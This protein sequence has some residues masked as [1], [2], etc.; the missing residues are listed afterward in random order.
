M[1][2]AEKKW[3]YGELPSLVEKGIVS[4]ETM[5]ALR[6]HYGPL[7]E[8]RSHVNIAFLITSITGAILISAGIIAIVAHNWDELGRMA[9]TVFSLLPLILAQCLYGYAFMKRRSSDAWME[10]TS[11]FLTLMMLSSMALISQTYNLGGNM[12]DLLL[13]W[14][15]LIL[16]VLYLRRVVL[17]F[18]FLMV[19]ICSRAADM[20]YHKDHLENLISY[21]AFILSICPFLYALLSGSDYKV[22]K[23]MAGW[24]LLISI[25]ISIPFLFDSDNVELPVLY[26]AL[27]SLMYL[28]GRYFYHNTSYFWMRPFQTAAIGGG[29]GL[30]LMYTYR[31]ISGWRMTHVQRH[32]SFIIAVSAVV[33]L[34]GLLVVLLQRKNRY[35]N[36]FPAGMVLVVVLLQLLSEMGYTTAVTILANAFLLSYAV[37]YIWQGIS[38]RNVNIVN[39]GMLFISALAIARFFE[40]DMDF[41]IKGLGFII[42]GSGFLTANLLINRR[43]KQ[44]ES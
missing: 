9:R 20:E 2:E 16:P 37:Y 32:T 24:S 21:T 25:C 30:C 22:G 5:Q 43:L 13:V 33:L 42:V 28:A 39:V 26:A 14:G 34:S 19:C 10:S 31:F 3:L 36:I 40:S 7:E 4:N 44:Y 11:A 41:L 23:T 17:P 15:I 35:I 18:I 27:S 1:A 6:D 29:Y 12:R 8:D 38:T